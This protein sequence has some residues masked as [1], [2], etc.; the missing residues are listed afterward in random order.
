MS[1]AG[2]GAGAGSKGF[3]RFDESTYSD[4]RSTH[5]AKAAARAA[6]SDSGRG[7]GSGNSAG[8]AGAGAGSGVP[9]VVKEFVRNFYSAV[10]R[11]HTFDIT[12]FYETEWNRI[13]ERH[14]QTSPWPSVT[15]ISPICKGDHV[16]KV[17]Y[18]L[19][20]YRH[21]MFYLAAKGVRG[22]LADHIEAWSTYRDF[23]NIV[24]DTE[25]SKDVELPS[26]WLYDLLSEFI[27]QFTMFLQ[28]RTQPA[29]LAAEERDRLAT[30]FAD[31]WSLVDVLRALH[32]LRERSGIVG[33]LNAQDD[34][35]D[36]PSGLLPQLGYF[37][38]VCLCRLHC[39]LGDYSSA[40]AIVSPM[41]LKSEAIFT[42]VAACHISL[43]YHI[44][45]A[46]IMSRRYVEAMRAY[47]RVLLYFHRTKNVHAKSVQGEVMKKRA[48]QMLGLLAACVVLCPGQLAEDQV[49]ALM[50][51]N[52][53]DKMKIMASATDEGM[54]L[55]GEVFQATCPAFLPSCMDAA[56][57][58]VSATETYKNQAALFLAEAKARVTLLPA[59]RSYL[60]LYTNISTT[61]LSE[62][63]GKKPEDVQT[64][65]LG[66]KLKMYQNQGG[67]GQGATSEWTASDPMHF[68][69]DRDTVV[70]DE[71]E[72]AA[73]SG[74]FFLE[75]ISKFT[76]VMGD[77]TRLK[78]R[79]PAR[80]R[81]PRKPK[82]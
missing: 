41:N 80:K 44:G 71:V 13:T 73:Q 28:L 6:A 82:N 72:V 39:Q 75:N 51:A 59:T 48:D 47:S 49:F 9:D 56:M 12:R 10:K 3:N 45:F 62:F 64:E 76:K 68:H 24:L 16:F 58:E 25:Y 79:L 14:F 27:L 53:G 36:L 2:T 7:S 42:R 60:R 57:L 35:R 8:G 37:S 29:L 26:Q 66:L 15:L 67:V 34:S 30:E 19:L 54:R 40:L 46:L 21:V 32:M 70:I 52:H 65:L 74:D 23:F 63:L 1:G 4:R 18:R 69:I 22:S 77:V 81:G 78:G 38:L 20:Y 55:F 50:K 61:K 43:F 17:L 31:V 33:I 11:G 5:A